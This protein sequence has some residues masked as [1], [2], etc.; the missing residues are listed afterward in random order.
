MS[1]T[2]HTRKAFEQRM[3]EIR[4]VRERLAEESSVTVLSSLNQFDSGLTKAKLGL[5]RHPSGTKASGLRRDLR[6]KL[7]VKDFRD[8]FGVA[9]EWSSRLRRFRKAA[10]HSTRSQAKKELGGGN[11]TNK[12]DYEKE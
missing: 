10:K 1:K 2:Y 7:T 9:E 11:T 8:R 3:R 5:S 4:Q 12:I 6:G